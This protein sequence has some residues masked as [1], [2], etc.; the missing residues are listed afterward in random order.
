MTLIEIK[1]VTFPT[2]R[3][4]LN[5]LATEAIINECVTSVMVA[6]IVYIYMCTT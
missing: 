4:D 5:H 6:G 2:Q 3:R 1:S